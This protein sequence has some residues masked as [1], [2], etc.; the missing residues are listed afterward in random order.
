MER[1]KLAFVR[2]I[3]HRSSASERL[4]LRPAL[5][6]PAWK[7]VHQRNDG[8]DGHHGDGDDRNGG[9]GE[10]HASG[11][12]RRD[13][14]ENLRLP[15]R[16]LGRPQVRAAVAGLRVTG[17]DAARTRTRLA[18]TALRSPPRAAALPRT[19]GL[20]KPSR[21]TESSPRQ[22]HRRAVASVCGRRISGALA[23]GLQIPFVRT[24]VWPP[25][26][27]HAPDALYEGHMKVRVRRCAGMNERDSSASLLGEG[28]GLPR[29]W[30]SGGKD[31]GTGR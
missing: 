9:Q 12:F 19:F 1:G 5:S 14:L 3:I 22:Q 21:A 28:D 31:C 30:W 16:R 8:D 11:S 18:T 15:S 23:F 25:R 4:R 27:R 29:G 20:V 13:V 6:A 10:E 17:L 7:E 26:R 24:G 2:L